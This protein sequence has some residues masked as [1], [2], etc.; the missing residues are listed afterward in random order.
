MTKLSDAQRTDD[1]VD[2]LRLKL[3]KVVCDD[4][5]PTIR[6]SMRTYLRDKYF[7]MTRTEFLAY[8]REH[9]PYLLD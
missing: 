8:V 1:D 7:E 4:L 9:A 3:I 6:D 5:M 2:R